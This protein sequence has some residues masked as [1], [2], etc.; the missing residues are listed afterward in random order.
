MAAHEQAAA[1]D[2]MDPHGLQ[3]GHHGHT[4]IPVRVLT[5]VLI[6]LLFFTILTVFCSRAEVWATQTLGIHIPQLVNVL[7]ALSIAVVKSVLVAM[8]FM[9]LKYDNPLNSLVFAF[10]LF[11]FGLFL[12]FT[13]T[14]LGTRGVV[15]QYKSPA[16]YEGGS[17]VGGV[18]RLRQA[19][20]D[21]AKRL[22]G[23]EKFKEEMAHHA[24]A[25]AHHDPAAPPSNKNRSRPIRPHKA[26]EHAPAGETPAAG[27]GHAPEAPRP[28]H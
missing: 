4:I 23:V 11:A 22:G 19:Q 12:F 15:Y 21:E 17:G 8:Y 13:M 5:G 20:E 14:D 2:E 25:G 10:C 16:A 24:H 28:G 7:I 9:Q 18:T 27:E 26:A 3:A 1:L 6:I